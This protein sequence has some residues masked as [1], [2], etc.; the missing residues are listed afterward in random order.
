[1]FFVP[2]IH[3]EGGLILFWKNS[4]KLKV[5]TFSKKNIDYSINKGSEGA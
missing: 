3:R 4:I 5:E 1:M 2:Q